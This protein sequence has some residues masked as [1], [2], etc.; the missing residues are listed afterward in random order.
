M[1]GAGERWDGQKVL[2]EAELKEE[3]A[4]S[5]YSLNMQNDAGKFVDLYVP[6]KC[7]ASNYIIGAKDQASIQMNVAEA[8]KVT[9]WFNGHYQTYAICGAILRMGES[10]TMMEL[11]QRTLDQKKLQDICHK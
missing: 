6:R 4:V 9:G 5:R 3:R 7:S 2:L 10:W 11:S 1:S 8:G